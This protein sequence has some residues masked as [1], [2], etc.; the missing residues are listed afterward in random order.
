MAKPSSQEVLYDFAQ[1]VAN[2]PGDIVEFGT[3]KGNNAVSFLQWIKKEH[4]S[5]IYYG[6]E[7]FCGYMEGDYVDDPNPEGLRNN[8]RVPN[9]INPTSTPFM[10]MMTDRLLNRSE[11]TP[12]TMEINIRGRVKITKAMVV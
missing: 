3:G 1:D 12:A 11:N 6:F 5:K 2:V 4:S 10:A 7:S 9:P 8:A